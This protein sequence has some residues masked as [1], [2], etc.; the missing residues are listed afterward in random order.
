[1]S[2]HQVM[3]IAQR[4]ATAFLFGEADGRQTRGPTQAQSRARSDPGEGWG[5]CRAGIVGWHQIVGC[6]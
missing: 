5:R 3:K 2:R 6:R 1:M 4:S